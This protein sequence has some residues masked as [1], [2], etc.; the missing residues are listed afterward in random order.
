M[1]WRI[2]SEQAMRVA[3]KAGKLPGALQQIMEGQVR[4]GRTDWI[5]ILREF[6]QRASPQNYSWTQ[7]NRR[8]L[9]MGIRMPGFTR[10]E[11][12]TIAIAVDTS[13]SVS[14]E[15]FTAFLS[16]VGSL[17]S[18]AKPKRI[19]LVQCDVTVSS[20]R[21]YQPGDD[22]PLERHG[23]GGT[24]FQPVFDRLE[25]DGETPVALLY[26]TDL[27]GDKPSEP[28]YPVLWVTPKWSTEKGLFGTT[29]RM[30]P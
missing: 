29:V 2:A 16:E 22:V 7:P 26:F 1:D 9:A 11:L 6:V 18:E 17:L 15:T 24:R 30:T 28:D 19:I 20:I 25:Q 5:A 8:A 10:N 27:Y 14:Q 4:E 13:G 23:G 3:Q 12:G 21:E